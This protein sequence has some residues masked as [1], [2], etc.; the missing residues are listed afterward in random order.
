M[1]QN[2]KT[3]TTWRTI[4]ILLFSTGIVLVLSTIPSYTTLIN[5]L[6]RFQPDGSFDSLS[7]DV[8]NVLIWISRIKG[9]VLILAGMYSVFNKTSVCRLLNKLDGIIKNISI[10]SDMKQ[11]LTST[12]ENNEKWILL[13]LGIIT[14]F[15]LFTR[16]IQYNRTVGYD[17]AYTFI[18]FASRSLRTIITDYSAPNN[19]IF[20]SLL[21][22]LVYLVFGN[23]LWALRLPSLIAGVVTIPAAYLAARTFY[24]R[25]TGLLAA[26]LVSLAPML[27]D[28]SNNARGYTLMCLFACLLLWLAGLLRQKSTFSGWFLLTITAVLGF[29]T[30]PVMVYPVSAIFLWLLL[31]WLVKDINENNPNKFIV[32]FILSSFFTIFLT[33]LL[34]SPVLILGTGL[35]SITSNEFVQSQSWS[36]F[37]QSIQARLARVW[38]EWNGMVPGWITSFTVTGFVLLLIMEWRNFKH[39]VPLW[40]AS[41]TAIAIL[42]FV[43]RVAPWP[44]V[45]LFLLVFYLIWSAAGWVGLANAVSSKVSWTAL[46]PIFM[47]ILLLAVF[48][49]Y[50]AYRNDPN[51]STVEENLTKDIAIYISENITDQDTLV[52]VAPFSIQVGYYL[53]ILEIP[54]DRFYDRARKGKIQHGIVIVAE[55]SK[56]PTLESVLAFQ[57][58]EEVL[59]IEQAQLIHQY[60]RIQVYN[61]PVFQRNPD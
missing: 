7:N 6:G 57:Q 13:S 51:Y 58:L 21:V 45:W 37:F 24:G 29:Y 16:L 61:V 1:Q 50:L 23:H 4:T 36:D 27:V 52:A 48:S 35:S 22:H 31:C 26:A 11:I 2:K 25:F 14:L 40:V 8:Y 9:G 54:F 41:L 17:E 56:F 10:K 20:H 34:Y 42:L 55:R 53:S 12:Y 46:R 49:G 3:K 32:S 60:K 15:G 19:H 47:S 5:F 30:L 38:Q 39:K 59:D 28:Y 33:I 18:H 43:Q 44:R